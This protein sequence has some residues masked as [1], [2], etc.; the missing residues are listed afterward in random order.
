MAMSEIYT[1]CNCGYQVE[2]WDEG[3][4][5][6]ET[7]DGRR[8]Y[9]YHP[10]SIEDV[11]PI[12]TA[13]AGRKLDDSEFKQLVTQRA[14]NASDHLCVSCGKTTK[15]DSNKDKLACGKCHGTQVF[16][17]WRCQGK[18]CPK[19]GGTFSEGSFNA[20]S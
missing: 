14:G 3:N 16:E 19:C 2:A 6:V 15:L 12:L 4:P 1:C 5:Y 11:R 10:G 17:I 13:E 8:H 9:F 20:I 7:T 18:L